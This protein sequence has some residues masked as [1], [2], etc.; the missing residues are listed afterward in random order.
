MDFCTIVAR[1]HWA[2][3]RVL[4]R[5]L[6]VHHPHSRFHVLLAE[7][8]PVS[9]PDEILS[10]D[11]HSLEALP[12]PQLMAWCFQYPFQDL[13]K[14]VR[15]YWLEH[16]FSNNGCERLL[17]LDVPTLVFAPLTQIEHALK[18]FDIVLLPY[19]NDTVHHKKPIAATDAQW[20]SIYRPECLALRKGVVTNRLFTY[21]KNAVS[22]AE[23][24][25]PGGKPSIHDQWIDLVP[26]YFENVHIVRDPGYHLGWW[27][28]EDQKITLSAGEPVFVGKTV[29]LCQLRVDTLFEKMDESKGPTL[30]RVLE[31]SPNHPLIEYYQTLLRAEGHDTYRQVPD[32]LEQYND[33]GLIT[34]EDRKHYRILGARAERFGDPFDTSSANSFA[35]WRQRLYASC[36]GEWTAPPEYG[37]NLSGFFQSEKGL[38][39]A[40]RAT[41]SAL[42]AANIP[43]VLNNF[44]DVS[45]N[46][47]ERPRARFSQNN[48]YSF[49]ILHF[50]APEVPKFILEYGKKY[51]LGR[52]NIGFWN[53]E[54]S[55][56]P[57]DWKD[58]FQVF[59]EIWVPSRFT[60]ESVAQVSPIPVRLVPFAITIPPGPPPGIDRQR[61]GLPEH[62]FLFLFAFD[63]QS[64]L[65]RKNPLALIDAFR[66]AFGGRADV[67]LVLKT[68][69][70][71]KVPTLHA[72][73]EA[74]CRGQ[75]N[76]YHVSE[77]L[78]RDAMHGLM[79]LCDSYISLHRS[80]GY[81][82]T[83]CEAMA[84][85]KPVIATGYSANVDFMNDANSLLVQ[86]RLVEIQQDQGHYQRG[87]AWAEPDVEHAAELMRRVVADADLARRL[88]ERARHDIT[89]NLHPARVGTLIRQ[90]LDDLLMHAAPCTQVANLPQTFATANLLWLNDLCNIHHVNYT[91]ERKV[92]GRL[93]DSA[94]K[95][96]ARLLAP[97]LQ[98]QINYN[99]VLKCTVDHLYHQMDTQQTQIDRLE[100]LL[101]A[102]SRHD[103]ISPTYF[104]SE[105]AA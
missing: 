10:C 47:S 72:Q 98:R 74:A 103:H 69:H 45:S 101:L 17:Y 52:Y 105:K 67:G 100:K 25:E 4:A 102:A 42:Q 97:V 14:I 63:F 19:D 27:N 24:A 37:I 41:L 3:A 35:Q 46:N 6:A 44:V 7:R 50:N 73:F 87:M 55:E 23:G 56:F 70:A 11:V 88:G 30:D 21:W 65:G 77:V 9:N 68:T 96:T 66:R 12:I 34:L 54:L 8:F 40:T 83:L 85:G 2:A 59:H 82:L 58:Y 81:G 84:M 64:T 94:R 62:A 89:Q 26:A 16:L 92:I 5:C 1:K 13:C 28:I 57:S 80:E 29:S 39:E 49:N 71:Q 43:H 53:W 93:I 90:R 99:Q 31:A 48:P 20:H 60:Q 75:S 22:P 51:L 15:P 79:W 32:S 95:L 104:S 91:S 33:G 36:E 61:F 86:Y 78:S 38:G 18:Q 76:I